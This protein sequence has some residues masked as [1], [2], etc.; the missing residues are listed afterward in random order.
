MKNYEEMKK[1]EVN[2]KNGTKLFANTVEDIMELN[3]RLKIS[4]DFFKIGDV[5]IVRKKTIVFI[6]EIIS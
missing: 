4:G 2:L 6:E 1:Y 3:L 5:F